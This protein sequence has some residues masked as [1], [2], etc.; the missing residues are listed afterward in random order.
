MVLTLSAQAA[1]RRSGCGVRLQAFLVPGPSPLGPSSRPLPPHCPTRPFYHHPTPKKAL[2][3]TLQ[4]NLGNLGD[5][6]PSLYIL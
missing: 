6:F 4:P 3:R 2:G 1:C 5:F